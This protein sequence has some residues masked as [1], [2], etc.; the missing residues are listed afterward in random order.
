M[1]IHKYQS[2]VN[3]LVNHLSNDFDV[4]VHIDKNSKIRISK[5]KN[6]FV[7]NK[8]RTPW[9]SFNAIKAIILLVNTAYQND[10]YDRYIYLS[11]QDLPLKNNKELTAFFCNNNNEYIENYYLPLEQWDNCKINYYKRFLKKLYECFF[12]SKLNYNFYSGSSWFCLTNNCIRKMMEY[13]SSDKMFI[14]I[15]HLTSMLYWEDCSDEKFFQTLIHR[16]IG[17]KIINHNLHYIDWGKKRKKHP[18]TLCI[19]DYEK[20]LYSNALFA[21][22]FD[23]T[24]DCEI[25][26]KIY[27]SI[28]EIAAGHRAN[29]DM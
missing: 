13:I 9:G 14:K 25:I 10:K 23:E 5:T 15:F 19:Q 17:L 20:V 26:D 12:K 1:L 21:R 7:Y 18:L 22:K 8:Y 11:G 2:Q 3:R 29:A 4:Y 28:N 27:I 24:I 16:I 6:V